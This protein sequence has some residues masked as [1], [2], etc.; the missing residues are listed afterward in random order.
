MRMFSSSHKNSWVL[1]RPSWPPLA[2]PSP[3]NANSFLGSCADNLAAWDSKGHG[4]GSAAGRFGNGEHARNSP[5]LPTWTAKMELRFSCGATESLLNQDTLYPSAGE[6]G[7]ILLAFLG[8]IWAPAQGCW[9]VA[10]LQS[11]ASKLSIFQSKDGEGLY[12]HRIIGTKGETVLWASPWWPHIQERRR[13]TQPSKGQ[14]PSPWTFQSTAKEGETLEELQMSVTVRQ[15]VWDLWSFYPLPRLI[16]F[17]FWHNT[18]KVTPGRSSG[19]L[20]DQVFILHYGFAFEIAFRDT[21]MKG[22]G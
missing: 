3:K 10:T 6:F 17:F 2:S 9:I 20:A 13:G 16:R 8:T 12:P 19:L 15:Q 14:T 4:P 22:K 5:R 11:P 18:M 1:H 21:T 7:E